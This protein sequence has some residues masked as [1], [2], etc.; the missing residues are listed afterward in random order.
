M[1]KQFQVPL[2]DTDPNGFIFRLIKKAYFRPQFFRSSVEH[3]VQK[4]KKKK[5]TAA[6]TKSLGW[7]F[8]KFFIIIL[9]FISF[10]IIALTR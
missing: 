6:P 8:R 4:K 2:H 9:L 3:T 7:K 10:K 1:L 5:G